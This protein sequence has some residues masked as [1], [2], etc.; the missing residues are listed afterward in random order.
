MAVN[1]FLT[2]RTN[3]N[4]INMSRLE[5]WYFLICYGIPAVPAI[6]YLV[7]DFIEDSNYYGNATVSKEKLED[8]LAQVI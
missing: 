5:K 7:L 4:H 6:T 8:M 1:V 3:K 2:F